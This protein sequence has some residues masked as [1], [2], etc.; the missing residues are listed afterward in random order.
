MFEVVFEPA[1]G[2]IVEF[3]NHGYYD[4]AEP[5]EG[6]AVLEITSDQY[7]A[8]EQYSSVVNGKLSKKAP[9]APP[10]P[11]RTD[12]ELKALALSQ[13]SELLRVAAERIAPLQDAADLETI[14]D[15]EAKQLKAWKTYRVALNRIQT[16]SGFPK[17][18]KWP[19]AP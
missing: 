7:D 9:T 8:R 14:T 13:Q 15:D 19:T 1:T 10:E 11:E 16:Q 6:S 17:T 12:D 2:Q 4:Y 18:I 3:R 5:R